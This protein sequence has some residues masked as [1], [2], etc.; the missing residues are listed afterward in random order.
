MTLHEHMNQIRI[1]FK[2]T[3]FSVEKSTEVG[4]WMLGIPKGQ[5]SSESLAMP[6]SVD[7]TSAGTRSNPGGEFILR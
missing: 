2:R 6:E 3:A 7:I 5:S 4:P 1:R